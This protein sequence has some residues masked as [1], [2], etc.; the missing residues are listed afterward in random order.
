MTTLFNFMGARSPLWSGTKVMQKVFTCRVAALLASTMLA[1]AY[2][3]G[4]A[5]QNAGDATVL[6][7]IV[8]QG[9]SYETEGTRSYTTDLI[10]VGEK[11]A[12]PLR[13]IPQS[14]TVLTRERLDDGGFTSLDTA[15]KKTPG[16][17][18]LTNDDGRSSLYSRGFEF[19]TLYF[20]GLPA[21][22]SSIHGTQPDMAMIDHIEILRGPAGLFGGT[23]EPAGAINMRLKQAP[24]AFQAQMSATYGSWN[25]RRIEADIGGPLNA[26]GTVRGRLVGALGKT[27][28]FVDVINNQIGTIYGTLQADLTENTTATLSI[29]HQKRDI[30]PF[31]GLPSLANGTLLDLDRSTFVGADWN[32][33]DSTVTDY[34]AEIEH[35]FDDGGHVKASA[36]YSDRTSDFL[37][38]Y[39][40]AAASPAGTVNGMRWLARE[41]EERALALDAHISKPFELWGKENNIILGA[42][43]RNFDYSWNNLTALIPG[44]YD[45]RNWNTSVPR[46][47]VDFNSPSTTRVKN[48]LKQYGIYGQWRH[49]PLDN[50]TLIGGGRLTWVDLSTLDANE[51]INARFTPYAGVIYDITDRISAYASYTEIFQ[52]QTETT[53]A[54][55]IIGPRTG[56]QFEVGVKANLFDDV[57]AS[58]AYFNLRDRNRAVRDPDNLSFSLAQGQAQLQGLEMELTGSLTP[59]WQVA[60]GYTYTDTKFVNTARVPG[61]EFYTP[62]HMVQ[63]WTKYTFDERHGLLN[64]A[65]IGGG[66]K[67]FSSFSNLTRS[68]NAGTGAVGVTEIK[69]PGYAVV[70]LQAGYDFNENLSAVLSVNN[71]FDTKYY[72]RVGGTP[73]FNFYGA[74]RNVN[75]KVTAK[76]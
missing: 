35:R 43:Y 31:N 33:F 1:S 46:P 64:K 11:D 8:V 39:A 34:I 58:I 76:F 27:D 12:R 63:L 55:S 51:T 19:D 36:R 18:V 47:T 10:S 44:T 48:D 74:P 56:Q 13:E 40:A 62:E 9:A 53:V 21:P 22:L 25:N 60:A 72:E 71:V 2:S 59:N 73:V 37:Y 26:A 66:V 7:E 6:E 70:D 65:F 28:N 42:D 3:P 15:L 14:T 16:V 29:S 61:A 54:G 17:V 69:A 67:V 45:V 20:N 30:T 57:N 4:A 52:P 41:F 23:G 49:K 24:D 38:G 5:A 68:V 32:R 50:L 75:F